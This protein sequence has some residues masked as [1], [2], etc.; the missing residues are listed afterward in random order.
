[1]RKPTLLSR[2]IWFVL[3]ALVLTVEAVS[4]LDVKLTGTNLLDPLTMVVID[5]TRANPETFGT[6][7][8][9]LLAWLVIHFFVWPLWKQRRGG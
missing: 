9:L 4:L 2:K 8:F 3:F 6:A 1:M 7:V 5:Q